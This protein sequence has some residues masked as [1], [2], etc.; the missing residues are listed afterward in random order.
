MYNQV[1]RKSGVFSRKKKNGQLES[2]F[3]LEKGANFAM[4]LDPERQI[5]YVTLRGG[6][7]KYRLYTLL[8]ALGMLDS[9]MKDAWGSN[10]F[11][12]N[13]KG[14]LNTE[15]SEL[16]DLYKKLV[17]KRQ[18]P[19]TV[20]GIKKGL[21]DYFSETKMNPEVNK[22][23]LGGSYDTVNPEA[24]LKTS[25][26]LLKINK[27]EEKPD[28][29]DSLIFKNIY[30]PDDLL[31]EYF[32][33][34]KQQIQ[35]KMQ[36][37]LS[38]RTQVREVVAANAFTKPVRQFFT[39]SDLS[40]TPPQTNPLA[41]LVN[42]R[43]TTSMGEGGIQNMHSITMETRDVQPSHFGFLDPL[44]TPES[45]KTG[46]TVGLAS[47]VVKKDNQMMAPVINAKTG[48]V[49]YK[50][51]M[52]MYNATVGFPD[53][54]ELKDGKPKPL[55]DSIKALKNHKPTEVKPSEID[56][57][58][59]S[60][61]AMFDYGA[62][63]VPYLSTTQG[64]RAS[65]AGRMITQ[66]LPLDDPDTPLTLTMRDKARDETY[67]DQVGS[68]LLPALELETKDASIGGEVTKIDD[69][70]IYI[71]GEDNNDYKVGLYKDF[72]L[73]Q[74]GYLNSKPVVGV[75]DKVKGDQI[76]AKS[77]YTDDKGRLAMGKNLSVAYV[78]YKGNA[79]EDAATITESA[80]KKLS[81]SQVNRQ[82]IF[83][84]PKLSTFSLRKFRS[85]F[86]EEIAP[87]NAKKLDSEGL[88][89]V[90][91][92][93]MP[94]EIL[95]A[96]LVKK[97]L[98][99]LD[100]SLK[101]LNK[102]VYSPYSKNITEWDE[103][104]PGK[105]L[106]VRKNGRNIDIVIK[107]VHPFKQGDKLSSR[108][109]DKH[110]VG[111]IIPDDEAPHRPNG[112]PVEIM[113]NP[114]GVQGRMNM[115]Q[116]LD[117][118]AGKIALAKGEPVKVWN[119]DDPDGDAAKKV[120]QD[121]QDAG[122]EANEI[123]TDGKN[124]EPLKNPVFVG[125]R[126]YL[127]L[128]HIVKKKQSAHDYGVYDIEEQPAGKGAQ[129][130]GVLD[131]YS[132]LAHGSK[133]LLREA[134]SIKG[135][136]NEEYFRN[137]QFGLPP[138]K[139]NSNLVFEKMM[140][141]IK[142]SGADIKKEGNKLQ[143]MPLTDKK[144][145][146]LS[147]GEIPDP[148]AMLIGKNLAS[149]KGGL[150]DQE[151]TGGQRGDNYNHIAL[152]K[153]IPNPMAEL[154]IK[155]ILGLTNKRYAAIMSGSEELNGK[156][157]AEAI[158]DALDKLD[159]SS[160][161]TTTKAELDAAPPTNV[162]KLNTKARILDALDKEGMNAKDA[163][164]M[165]KVLVIP[166]KFRPIYPLPSGDLQVSDINKHYRDIGLKAKG[167]K[168]ALD[169]DLLT[170]EEQVTYTKGMYDSVKAAQGFID[171]VTYGKQKY[172]GGLKELG[173][174]K[175]GLIFGKAWGKR[176]DLSGRSTITP[177]PSLGLDEIGIPKPIAEK[178]M[179]PFV[180]RKLKQSGLSAKKAKQQSREKTDLF[181]RTLDQVMD[182]KPVI[183]NRAPSLH[184]HSVQ[185]FKPKLFEGK[186]IRLNPMVVGGFNADFDGDTMSVMVP[187]TYEGE[188]EALSM[189][190]S[191]NLFKAGDKSLVP[192]LSQEF[193][194]GISKLSE[195]G[196]ETGKTFSGIREAKKE[197]KDMTDVFTVNGQKMTLGQHE[198]NKVLPK[199]YQDYNRTFKRKDLSKFLDK[200][201]RN[202]SSELF[203]DVI[204]HYKSL[205]AYYAYK[206]GG[207]ISIDDMVID[208]SYRDDIIDKYEPK[209]KKIKDKDKKVKAYMDM[210][211]EIGKAQDETL[212][213]KNRM[214][215]LIETGALSASKAGNVRQVLSAPGVVID[216]KGNAVE[217]PILKSYSE[218]LDTFS[219]FNTLPGVRKG[220]VDRSVNTQQ[221][222]ALNKSLLSVN[223]RLV[224]VEEDC[225]TKEYIELPINEKDVM[226]RTLAVTMRGIGRRNDIVDGGI[227]NAAKMRGQEMLK[228]RSPLT[229][230][231]VQGV[232]QKCYGVL[233]NGKLPDVGTNVGV[234]ESQALTE[235]ST[236]L[237]MQT[238]HS[239][240]AAGSGNTG[241]AGSF[242][243]IEQLIKVP[244]KLSGKATL[245]KVGGTVT[246]LEKNDIGGWDVTVGQTKHVISPGRNPVIR[247]G[248][249]VKKGDRLSDGSIKPQELSKLKD[250][251]TAQRYIV[252]EI[253]D[254][255][256]DSFDKKS[257]ETVIRGV[258]DNAVVTKA[259]DDS[260]FFR[261]DKSSASYI[262]SVNRERETQNLDPIE[263]NT[264]FKSIDTL[265][266][267][268]DDWLTKI[269]T[270]RIKDGLS[271]GMAKMQWADVAGKDPI[272]AYL[273]GDDFGQPE[274]KR[275]DEGGFY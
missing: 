177:E 84:N 96:F 166:P 35:S 79:F 159:V 220:V 201:A 239:G 81:H 122:I 144:V 129:K 38:N 255:Y 126:Q 16:T 107:S 66:A 91:E 226:D 232:C 273:Y 161:L 136:K 244:E 252:D 111:K 246:G 65:T 50:S 162:N 266:V 186:E 116:I 203:A 197:I 182:E 62:N 231:S 248:N 265:N 191:K 44:S 118:A 134:T 155:S 247:E 15:V 170:D 100:K 93:F 109:G 12:I 175:Q 88:P 123:L 271:R 157:G 158:I 176:Q 43:K 238:F 37:S 125:N 102:A 20:S 133:N 221:S 90:G 274:R 72:P 208:R 48:K 59:R 222:G 139:P 41:M 150:F 31:Q 137:L 33:G 225:G 28:E 171:P 106:D 61:A 148:G 120:Y 153:R 3:N 261:G 233:P 242:P 78:S 174:T 164:T 115:G 202:E 245:A 195:M 113:I 224:V 179:E 207:T 2:E 1:R 104:V 149:K 214:L 267:D 200:I 46:V 143:L 140:N 189:M 53:Q 54:F 188:Q 51:P 204:D 124:G 217:I 105:V 254:I 73:N 264:Y 8:S 193:V 142:A 85:T 68:Y 74:D 241:V 172:K 262:K 4:Q 146:E 216:T 9:E 23:T 218:G 240:G 260:E 237:T 190:P 75:G 27:G 56:F 145:E 30:A 187:V 235:R 181:Y 57:Y 169:E 259:P 132:Y 7:R 234:L 185:A 71:K 249:K 128:R 10:L 19:D 147:K 47:E 168:S 64:N 29:R 87:A 223:R 243:R 230:D 269:T 211:D 40:S 112:E 77:N 209:I 141:Y 173:G 256:G 194:Y 257:I 250:H 263:F 251:L 76:L 163:Y 70:Y 18:V 236:Q 83:F 60:P 98:D 165:D 227:V 117:T 95:A 45:L 21:R 156:T 154:A 206:V 272:P 52:D 152:P 80:A 86:P 268:N 167:M 63:M 135:R 138:S 121:L 94:G 69:D 92:E 114:Q 131:T 13:K 110:I 17:D 11:E 82:D 210:M 198:L 36:N 130:V 22:I 14:A 196:E 229:C 199:K 26:K 6:T 49:E 103:D 5:Y 219:Y 180:V 67:E 270:N 275:D 24:L 39:T 25:E 160:E 253:N 108:Y 101:K 192:S 205:G 55:F 215:E 89:K 34:H 183:V 99:D 42:A 151:I 228:V 58:L 119:F 97:E 178:I 212:G 213:G 184:K 258:S 32:K 127:K